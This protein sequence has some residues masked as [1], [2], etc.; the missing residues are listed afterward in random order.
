MP[1]IERWNVEIAGDYLKWFG[2]L[3][4]GQQDALR[5]DIEILEKLDRLSGGLTST[6]SKARNTRT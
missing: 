6:R 3:E 2:T 1:P 5:T 4:A